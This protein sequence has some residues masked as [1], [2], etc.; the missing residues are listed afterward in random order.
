[1]G[2]LDLTLVLWLD[3]D[4]PLR[5]DDIEPKSIDV[6]D[7]V[8]YEDVDAFKYVVDASGTSKWLDANRDDVEAVGFNKSLSM[9]LFKVE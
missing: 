8:R 6:V 9:S 4:L 7:G 1:M 5:L 3:D 2:E